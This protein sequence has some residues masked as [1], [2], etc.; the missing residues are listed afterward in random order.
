MST[1]A[2]YE[3]ADM[4]D[5]STVAIEENKRRLDEINASLAKIKP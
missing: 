5:R 4:I 1:Q 3:N 2:I